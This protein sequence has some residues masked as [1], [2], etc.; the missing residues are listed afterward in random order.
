MALFLKGKFTG[1]YKAGSSECVKDTWR[2][3]NAG[4]NKI[5][6]IVTRRDQ[7]SYAGRL[8]LY[9]NISISLTPVDEEQ[10]RLGGR[11]QASIVGLNA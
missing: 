8:W 5:S 10:P 4:K 11:V 7:E 2:F 3:Y 6:A 9:Q 1:F